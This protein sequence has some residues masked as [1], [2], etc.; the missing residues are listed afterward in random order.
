MHKVTYTQMTIFERRPEKRVVGFDGRTLYPIY[1][2]GEH[3]SVGSLENKGLG[4]IVSSAPHEHYFFRLQHGLRY[5][6]ITKSIEEVSDENN[7]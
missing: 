4:R 7:A 3:R 2:S 6:Y 5:N 1:G